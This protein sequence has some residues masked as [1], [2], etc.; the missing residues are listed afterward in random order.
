[1]S[2]EC[3]LVSEFAQPLTAMVICDLLGVELEERDFLRDWSRDFGKL[4]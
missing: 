1:M 4:I 3:D 2:E